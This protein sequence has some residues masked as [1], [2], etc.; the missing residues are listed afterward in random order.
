MSSAAPF[1]VEERW[2]NTYIRVLEALRKSYDFRT[3]LKSNMPRFQGDDLRSYLAKRGWQESHHAFQLAVHT[4]G[5]PAAGVGLIIAIR[6]PGHKTFR[7]AFPETLADVANYRTVLGEASALSGTFQLQQ[8]LRHQHAQV[9][10]SFR[11]RSPSAP[12]IGVSMLWAS[13]ESRLSLYSGDITLLHSDEDDSI[14]GGDGLVPR[15]RSVDKQAE[16]HIGISSLLCLPTTYSTEKGNPADV[17]FA[18]YSPLPYAFGFHEGPFIR[19]T[20]SAWPKKMLERVL[21]REVPALLND[22]D[23]AYRQGLRTLTTGILSI[24][25]HKFETLTTSLLKEAY[26]WLGGLGL[27]LTPPDAERLRHRFED[28]AARSDANPHERLLK[29]YRQVFEL[30]HTPTSGALDRKSLA[31]LYQY[32]KDQHFDLIGSGVDAPH[33]YLPSIP[34]DL[35]AATSKRSPFGLN[36]LAEVVASAISGCI[37][38]AK[39]SGA[40]RIILR[41]QYEPDSIIF[42][43]TND[44]QY[45]A[46]LVRK[47]WLV[48]Q[49]HLVRHH[50]RVS[51]GSTGG[52]Q[53]YLLRELCQFFPI[54]FNVTL[55]IPPV[56]SQVAQWS[57]MLR[58]PFSD[59]SAEP[60]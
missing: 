32:T 40:Q 30:P 4:A 28:L 18:F 53:L 43:I 58:V 47:Y 2:S 26:A 14:W 39:Q 46:D 59:R 19:Y 29:L 49:G 8:R 50:G 3:W 31:E 56:E 1:L 35:Q 25:E 38:N 48:R 21:P 15:F 23:S 44:I 10:C 13:M 60:I 11:V 6:M 34:P 16:D 54:D 41:H 20:D 33:L 51:Q 5:D 7:L 36:R 12:E 22:L 9:N 27:D 52:L 45:T 57:S 37:Y 55:A 17:V 42:T 24:I